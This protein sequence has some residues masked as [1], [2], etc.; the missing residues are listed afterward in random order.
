MN[1]KRAPLAIANWKM[2]KSP[3][4][5]AAFLDEFLPRRSGFPEGVQVAIAPAFPALERVGR[6]LLHSGVL[7]GAQDVHTEAKGAHTGEVSAP[8][9]KDLE[10]Q[11][12]LVGHS[13]R[14]RDRKEGESEC[15]KKI[16]RLL[17]AG[18]PAVYC[19]GETLE[20]REK[21][22]TDAVLTRQMTCFDAFPDG[23]PPGIVLAYE[24][25][26]AIGTGRAATPQMAQDAH[27][28][29]RGLLEKR[30]GAAH[31][32]AIRI[33]YGGSVTPANAR[34]LFSQPDIDGGLVGGASLVPK[35]FEAIVLAAG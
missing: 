19:V 6:L 23:P 3:R 11:L 12:A 10:V 2:N 32:E 30:Y 24:P 33:L 29:L 27:R 21:G 28:V 7:L 15:G 1:A 13:E 16:T 18:I 20:E 31:A 4:E 5:A 35:D 22:E 34:E 14:R 26:W 9:L 25:V 17:E 8:M